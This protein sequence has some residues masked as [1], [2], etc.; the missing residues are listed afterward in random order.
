[1]LAPLKQCSQLG[2]REL[3]HTGRCAA[4]QHQQP[5][6]AK[7]AARGYDKDHRRLRILCFER[8]QWRCVDCGWEP[9][10]VRLFR[11]AGL[12]APPTDHVLQALRLAFNHG[13][14]HLHA[15]H[16]IPIEVRPELRLELGNLATRCDRCHNRKTAREQ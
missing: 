3:T 7:T 6:R 13:A 14:R 1:M 9:D 15:D 5:E 16:Q 2:C 10:L 12:P 11:E 4:H 8:D